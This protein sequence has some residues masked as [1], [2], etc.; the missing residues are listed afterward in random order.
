MALVGEKIRKKRYVGEPFWARGPPISLARPPAGHRAARPAELSRGEE[1]IVFLT[2]IHCLYGCDRRCLY[3]CD[4]HCDRRCLYGCDSIAICIAIECLYGCDRHCDR[5][6]RSSLRSVI[7]SVC[8]G[9]GRFRL[10]RFRH[11]CIYI[12][13][14][15][16]PVKFILTLFKYLYFLALA[17][18]PPTR[19]RWRL[20]LATSPSSE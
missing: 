15:D 16:V 9:S 7:M 1:P 13:K 5:P 19:A 14:V 6:L 3:G 17:P 2:E 18:P 4:R 12:R 10:C 11:S 20:D 8:M